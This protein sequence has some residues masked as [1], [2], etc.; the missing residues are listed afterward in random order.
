LGSSAISYLED[1]Y[2][3]NNPS[4][5]AWNHSLDRGGDGQDLWRELTSEDRARHALF[6]DLLCNLEI[7]EKEFTKTLGPQAK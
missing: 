3:R 7:R 6:N 4:S 2:L 5:V 1:A